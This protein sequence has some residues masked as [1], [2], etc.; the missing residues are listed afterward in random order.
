MQ[1]G[2]TL[3]ELMIVV[4]I[5]AIIA[6]IA[7]PSLLQSQI[8]A[9]DTAVTSNFRAMMAANQTFYTQR[10]GY[11]GG[12]ANMYLGYCRQTTDLLNATI[13]DAAGNDVKIQNIDRTLCADENANANSN[14]YLYRYST[15]TPY[16]DGDGIQTYTGYMICAWPETLGKTGSKFFIVDERG[17]I[18]WRNADPAIDMPITEWPSDVEIDAEW[19][20]V[21]RK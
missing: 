16:V 12:L 21:A 2:F 6:A 11:S 9:K 13:K 8:A 14:G 19:K 4:A 5:I 3:I 1:K 20:A 17:I 10:Y 18:Y 7:I 15:T